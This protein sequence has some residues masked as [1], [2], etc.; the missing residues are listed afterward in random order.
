MSEDGDKTRIEVFGDPKERIEQREKLKEAV[1]PGRAEINQ[2]KHLQRVENRMRKAERRRIKRM[3][4]KRARLQ[5][6]VRKGF[7]EGKRPAALADK[8][9][10]SLAEVDEHLGP[11]RP[12]E[13]NGE[14]IS[15]L[16]GNSKV[17]V[18]IDVEADS[19]WLKEERRIADEKKRRDLW[20]RME[21]MRRSGLS[22][23]P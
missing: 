2:K 3:E 20:D 14:F 22:E 19:S 11:Y 23:V 17:L 9:G 18:S 7:I 13:K 15:E 12:E 21:K 4:R 10:I 5:Y 16:M 1:D 8:F 6:L